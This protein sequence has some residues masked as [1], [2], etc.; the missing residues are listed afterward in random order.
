MPELEYEP[1]KEGEYLHIKGER[2]LPDDYPVY[3]GH[4][5]LVNGTPVSSDIQGTVLA[6]KADLRAEEI[7][8]CKLAERGLL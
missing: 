4:V 7:R 3:A 2:I 6:L 5:Y 8:N 1:R